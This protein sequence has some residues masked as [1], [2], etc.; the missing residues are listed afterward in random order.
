LNDLKT[1]HIYFA[2]NSAKE[3]YGNSNTEENKNEKKERKKSWTGIFI[4][5]INFLAG[6]PDVG[7]TRTYNVA[8]LNALCFQRAV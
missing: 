5:L 8:R 7:I 1:L 2:G 6:A 3:P 4:E